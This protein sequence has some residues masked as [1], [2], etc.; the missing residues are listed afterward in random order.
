[1]AA[2]RDLGQFER[3]LDLFHGAAWPQVGLGAEGGVPGFD[4]EV[5]ET[6][7]DGVAGEFRQTVE[8]V[9]AEFEQ[10]GDHLPGFRLR[11]AEAADENGGRQGAEIFDELAGF[12]HARPPFALAGDGEGGEA[13]RGGADAHAPA[14]PV[15]GHREHSFEAAVEPFDLVGPEEGLAVLRRFD[16]GTDRFEPGEEG[17]PEAFGPARIGGDEAEGG[18]DVDRFPESHARPDAEACLLYTSPSPRDS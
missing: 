5:P 13:G 17:L 15:G 8:P 10:R 1:M 7:G 12:D 9:D 4:A 14:E 2:G 16:F 18:A 11:P 3:F 6:V